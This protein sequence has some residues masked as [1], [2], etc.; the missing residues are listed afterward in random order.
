MWFATLVLHLKR[1]RNRQEVGS[2][3]SSANAGPLPVDAG[4]QA[5]KAATRDRNARRALVRVGVVPFTS[6]WSP[7]RSPEAREHEDERCHAPGDVTGP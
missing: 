2:R 7:K 4:G 6:P 3:T 1:G 5:A